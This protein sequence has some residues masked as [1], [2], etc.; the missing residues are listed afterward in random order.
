MQTTPLRVLSDH[1]P[2]RVELARWHEELVVLKRLRIPSQILAERLQREA[3]VVQK[4]NHPNIVRL[5]GNEE[6]TLMY[7]YCPG[8]TLGEAL[9]DGPIR[10]DRSVRI[11]SDILRALEYAHSRGVIHCDVKP[12][13]ILLKGEQALLADFGFAKDLALASITR[14]GMMLGTPNYMAPEQFAGDRSDPRSDL[15]ALG[16]VLY[17]LITSS[18]PYG[19]QVVRFLIGDESIKLAPLPE[20]VKAVDGVVCRALAR[21]PDERFESAGAML[22][23]LQSAVRG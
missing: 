12:S 9:E 2:I 21:S 7:A 17:H 1:G 23:A 8:M 16:A 20:R 10:L 14:Q 6:N 22:E 15:Y 11:V 19:N 3:E 18:P 5:L 13:N 4:L